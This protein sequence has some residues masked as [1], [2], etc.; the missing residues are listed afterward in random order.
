MNIKPCLK[1]LLLLLT[2]IPAIAAAEGYPT[3]PVTLV[4]AYAPGGMTDILT[5]RVAADLQT[6]LGKPF[7][8]ENRPGATGQIATE[9]VARQKPDGYT[10][11]VGATSH[12]INPA[13][14]KLPYDARKDFEPVALFAVSPNFLLVNASMGI[15]SF[16]DFKAYAQ[17]QASIPYGTAGAGGAPHIVGELLRAQSGLPLL[18][19]SYRGAGPAMTDLVSGQVP[20]GIAESVTANAYLQSGKIVPLAIASA[21][22]QSRYPDVPTLD[23]LGYKNFNL[24]TWVGAYAPAGTPADILDTLNREIRQAISQPAIQ[25]YIRSTGSEPGSMDRPQYRHFVTEEMDKWQAVISQAGVKD[26]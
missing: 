23:E 5:R 25:E 26:E 11:L 15:K 7:V 10:V 22:R 14:K 13:L 9:Y 16:A 12:V 2:A 4:V 6:R 3:K 20:V 18:H 1:P 17:K 21:S 8:V 24:S 19:V